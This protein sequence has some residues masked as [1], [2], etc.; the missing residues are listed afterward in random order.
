MAQTGAYRNMP[1]R[2]GVAHRCGASA[3][4]AMPDLPE[5]R[6]ALSADLTYGPRGCAT[7]S[8]VAPAGAKPTARGGLLSVPETPGEH[9]ARMF[10][11]TA[12]SQARSIKRVY[13]VAQKSNSQARVAFSTLR[14]RV[15]ASLLWHPIGF[16]SVKV[17]TGRVLYVKSLCRPPHSA[18]RCRPPAAL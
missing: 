16:M 14:V 17:A 10:S 13:S 15:A 2:R 5:Q 3:A 1:A 11:L 9:A 8:F 6:R 7:S 4:T 18:P 12:P